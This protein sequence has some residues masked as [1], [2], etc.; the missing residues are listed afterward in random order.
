MEGTCLFEPTGIGIK[1]VEK[2]LINFKLKYIYCAKIKS[3]AVGMIL[4]K[5]RTMLGLFSVV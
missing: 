1:C 2:L 5:T 4:D 3:L